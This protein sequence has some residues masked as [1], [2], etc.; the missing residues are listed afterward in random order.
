MAD[1]LKN[2]RCV[3]RRA[4]NDLPGR[5]I[6]LGIE[7]GTGSIGTRLDELLFDVSQQDC[8]WLLPQICDPPV[9]PEPEPE[10]DLGIGEAMTAMM[11]VAKVARNLVCILTEGLRTRPPQSRMVLSDQPIHRK[12]TAQQSALL[13]LP[14]SSHGRKPQRD[15]P[16]PESSAI[17][18]AEIVS[19]EILLK[20]QIRQMQ[21]NRPH[22]SVCR[23]VPGI[24]E[25]R[26][27]SGI[28]RRSM[29]MIFRRQCSTCSS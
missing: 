26:P 15:P 1:D 18:D 29:S 3:S 27:F 7:H 11:A 2:C 9:E 5:S 23:L 16:L 10:F 8:T 14:R 19:S 24:F 28:P 20:R 6:L 25:P 17:Q 13:L 21:A 12:P 4:R 22:S